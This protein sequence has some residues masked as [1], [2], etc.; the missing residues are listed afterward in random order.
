VRLPL[1]AV[2]LLTGSAG[3]SVDVSSHHP[4]ARPV[5][6]KLKFDSMLQCGIP[7]GPPLVVTLP[8]AAHVPRKVPRT[9]VLVNGQ[10]SASVTVT[11]HVLA[12]RVAHPEVLCDVIGR[13]TISIA[14][15]HAVG[16][17][18]PAASGTYRISVRRGTQ[19]ETGTLA[20]RK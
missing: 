12:V 13:G 3:L 8:T 11:G 16:L 10:P 20:I 2:A 6:L 5:A 19:V 9:A 14:F 15:T 4:G 18:N 7:V 17:G 1:L